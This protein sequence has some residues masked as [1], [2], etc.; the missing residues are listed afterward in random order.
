M[1]KLVQALG[2][3]GSSHRQ[4]TQW[5]CSP[6]HPHTRPRTQNLVSRQTPGHHS[7][8]NLS[9]PM[10]KTPGTCEGRSGGLGKIASPGLGV[11]QRKGEAFHSHQEGGGVGEMKAGRM[12]DQCPPPPPPPPAPQRQPCLWGLEPLQTLSRPLLLSLGGLFS[13]PALP[14][15]P[16][17]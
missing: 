5:Q 7:T 13:G 2:F 12:G 8:Q 10:A 15:K 16:P 6:S 17:L 9:E 14:G 11:W 1:T 3:P 4:G